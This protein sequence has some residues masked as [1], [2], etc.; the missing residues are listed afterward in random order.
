LFDGPY[1]IKRL[2]PLSNAGIYAY[3]TSIFKTYRI[4][5]SSDFRKNSKEKPV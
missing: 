4:K 2:E 5:S 1:T 3:F